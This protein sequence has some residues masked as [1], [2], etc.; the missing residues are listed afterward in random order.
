MLGLGTLILGAALAISGTKA[1]IQDIDC[2]STPYRTTRDGKS[3]SVTRKGDDYINGE[4]CMSIPYTSEYG[5]TY[6]KTIGRTTGR[7]YEDTRNNVNDRWEREARKS[8]EENKAKGKLGYLKMNFRLHYC[9]LTEM[10]TGK[11]IASLSRYDKD[12]CY[13]E[14]L[15]PNGSF[16]HSGDGNKIKISNEEYE[17][18]SGIGGRHLN[19]DAL[20]YYRK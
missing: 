2:K 17:G 9:L 1:L 19:Y 12:T 18:L 11:Q 3:V 10:S 13:K 20:G 7:V 14:Y 4:A 16:C 15:D 6:Y 5:A 8:Y